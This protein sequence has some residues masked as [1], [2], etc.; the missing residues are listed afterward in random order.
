[1]LADQTRS[2]TSALSNDRSRPQSDVRRA[3]AYAIGQTKHRR[4]HNNGTCHDRLQKEMNR[5]N[6]PFT[7]SPEPLTALTSDDGVAAWLKTKGSWAQL[8]GGLW[9]NCTANALP[10][11]RMII[12]LRL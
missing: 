2:N 6:V 9:D 1:R 5:G 10:E 4:R 11:G 8:A 12:M 3:M 7:L